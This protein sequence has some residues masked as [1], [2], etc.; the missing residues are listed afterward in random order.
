MWKRKEKGKDGAET[1]FFRRRRTCLSR[2]L[3]PTTTGKGGINLSPRTEASFQ[4][5]QR[6][7]CMETSLNLSFLRFEDAE[8]TV[9]GGSGPKL[10]RNFGQK[11]QVTKLVSQENRKILLSIVISSAHSHRSNPA[12][13][14]AREKGGKASQSAVSFFVV[15]VSGFPSSTSSPVPFLLL[16]LHLVFISS[17]D[18]RCHKRYPLSISSPLL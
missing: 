3:L 8:P 7:I 2:D 14:R 16:F 12:L 6:V 15:I 5:R 11:V 10:S 4:D 13:E 9:V 17:D 1:H 18:E